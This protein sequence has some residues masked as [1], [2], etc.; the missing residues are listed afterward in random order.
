MTPTPRSTGK[1]TCKLG[2][3]YCCRRPRTNVV[4][5]LLHNNPDLASLNTWSPLASHVSKKFV[6]K[7]APFR[8]STSAWVLSP[9][10]FLSIGMMVLDTFRIRECRGL[11]GQTNF[12]CHSVDLCQ[13]SCLTGLPRSTDNRSCQ[14]A[15]RHPANCWW[16]CKFAKAQL[17]ELVRGS[18]TPIWPSLSMVGR[19]KFAILCWSKNW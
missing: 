5:S 14:M 13:M 10:L 19:V 16:S 3:L 18:T 1:P 11:N 8:I 15:G 12:P 17:T 9:F 4:S 6:M 2:E 7:P